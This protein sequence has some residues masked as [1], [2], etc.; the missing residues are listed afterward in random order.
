MWA[1]G[2]WSRWA[3]P[4]VRPRRPTRRRRPLPHEPLGASRSLLAGAPRADGF[5][6][7]TNPG[8]GAGRRYAVSSRWQ[9]RR[10][11]ALF[12]DGLVLSPGGRIELVRPGPTWFDTTWQRECRFGAGW[13]VDLAAHRF[14]PSTGR[15]S[16]GQV[17]LMGMT[18]V[19]AEPALQ[20]AAGYHLNGISDGS[21]AIDWLRSTMVAAVRR[22]SS[23]G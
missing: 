3:P 20:F 1:G 12:G 15:A 14:G 8:Y 19:W 2:C 4:R 22:G 9:P 16:F 21:T 23:A 18:A 5:A 10:S 7:G 17:G 11:A 13:L 6:R